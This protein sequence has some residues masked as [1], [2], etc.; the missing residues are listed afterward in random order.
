MTDTRLILSRVQR[1]RFCSALWGVLVT[2]AHL[3]P[4]LLYLAA[5]SHCIA[6]ASH[7]ERTNVNTAHV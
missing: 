6:L 5:L 4:L 2:P 1:R 3:C 7:T